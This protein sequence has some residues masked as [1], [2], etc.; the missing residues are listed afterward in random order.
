ML[1]SLTSGVT[2]PSW[3]KGQ[4]IPTRKAGHSKMVVQLSVIMGELIF[5]RYRIMSGKSF[6]F[7]HTRNGRTS[8]TNLTLGTPQLAMIAKSDGPIHAT[9]FPSTLSVDNHHPSPASQQVSSGS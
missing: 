3:Q 9:W 4:G 5:L 1:N 7:G 2:L 6:H 8:G